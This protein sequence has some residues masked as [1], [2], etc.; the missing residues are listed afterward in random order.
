MTTPSPTA[1]GTGPPT[2]DPRRP[3]NTPSDGDA[4]RPSIAQATSAPKF[5]TKPVIK[6]GTTDGGGKKLVLECTIEANPKPG[7]TWSRG[8]QP[9]LESDRLKVVQDEMSATVWRLALEIIAPKSDDAG[10][11][12]V[13]CKNRYGEANATLNVNFGAMRNTRPHTILVHT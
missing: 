1:E 6:P 8:D 7:I 2:E 5:V 12:K 10:T 11:Y 13:S 9:L 3:S 4:R